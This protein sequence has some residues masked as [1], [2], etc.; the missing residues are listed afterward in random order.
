MRVV[1]A[2]TIKSTCAHGATLDVDGGHELVV[3]ALEEDMIRVRLERHGKRAVDRSWMVAPGGASSVPCEG[4]PKE[5]TDGFA[6]PIAT[7]ETDA[8]RSNISIATSRLR[9]IIP[10]GIKPLALQWEWK[11]VAKGGQWLPLLHDR[12]TG[13]YYLG[14]GDSRLSHHVR[15]GRGDRFFGLGEKS[16][17]LNK[18]GRRYRMDCHDALGYNA[19]LSDPLYKFW[20]FYIAK[21]A[22]ALPGTP[23]T[24]AAYGMFYDNPASC[25]FDLGCAFDNYRELAS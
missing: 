6:M 2:A 13:A 24:S 14:R 20:P 19:E 1:G 4:R 10:L 9:V 23:T 12:R 5:A 22:N 18:A 8:T 3:T 11:D 21:P 17:A 15:R 25:T 7:V 16:G